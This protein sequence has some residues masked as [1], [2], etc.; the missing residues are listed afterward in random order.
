MSS[1][2]GYSYGLFIRLKPQICASLRGL[3]RNNEQQNLPGRK[4][5]SSVQPQWSTVIT[6][7]PASGRGRWITHESLLMKH[8]R[9]VT[10]T[11]LSHWESIQRQVEQIWSE[12]KPSRWYVSLTTPRG[13]TA[14]RFENDPLRQPPADCLTVSISLIIPHTDRGNLLVSL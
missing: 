1:W 8:W 4:S 3:P 7:P 9:V 2:L 13:A 11:Q 14:N 12:Y 6:W 10:S 5:Q